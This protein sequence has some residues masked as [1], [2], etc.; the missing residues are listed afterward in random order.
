[1]PKV[2]ELVCGKCSNCFRV[3][4]DSYIC[5]LW[6]LKQVEEIYGILLNTQI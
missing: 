3:S 5:V 1:M 6:G 2:P 4:C